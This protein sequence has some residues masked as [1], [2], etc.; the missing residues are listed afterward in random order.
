MARRTSDEHVSSPIAACSP[1]P[2]RQ[3]PPGPCPVCGGRVKERP[4]VAA[5]WSL[6]PGDPSRILPNVPFWQCSRCE[7]LFRDDPRQ[8]D[9]AS[10]Y[11]DQASYVVP[12][13][14]QVYSHIKGRMFREV[15]RRVTS[16]FNL[17]RRQPLAVDFGCSYGHLGQTFKDAGWDVMGVDI[18]P[19]IHEHHRRKGTFPT[20]A[21][22]DCPDI[23]DGQVDAICMIDVLCYI[24]DPVGLLR[25]AYRKLAPGGVLFLR[26]PYREQYIRWGAK[27]AWMFPFQ[28]T[29]FAAFDHVGFWTPKTVRVAARELG[30]GRC[31]ILWREKGYTYPRL[32]QTLFHR[33]TQFL[34]CATRGA[35]HLATVFQ[36]EMWKSGGS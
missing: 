11:Y 30:F 28:F 20:Y 23:P 2:T 4:I 6:L 14:E 25:V 29:A 16:R 13:N 7:Y 33:A 24:N 12:A 27:L 10:E 31:H 18:A 21:S 17:T 34:A 26:V 35:I 8:T 3:D 15:V 1:A 32:T 9:Q 36:A 19:S 5:A 22:L